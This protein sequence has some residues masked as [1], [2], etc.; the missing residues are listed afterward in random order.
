MVE[1]N[2]Q[3]HYTKPTR[4]SKIAEQAVV[5]GRRWAT[6]DGEVRLFFGRVEVSDH[7]T[8][9]RE[10]DERTEELVDD[11]EYD[12]QQVKSFQRRLPGEVRSCRRQH[13]NP[14]RIARKGAEHGYCR[15]R[16]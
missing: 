6:S 7:L 12:S 4:Y 13:L 11:V 14:I 5:D 1:H 2:K 3:P 16:R 15:D 9:Y 10:Y 8:G